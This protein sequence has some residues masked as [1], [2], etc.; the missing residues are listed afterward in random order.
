MIRAWEAVQKVATKKPRTLYKCWDEYLILRGIDITTREGKRG[1][2]R[3]KKFAQPMPDVVLNQDT[4]TALE[5]VLDTFQPA[6][7]KKGTL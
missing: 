6:E 5:L 2:G 7:I 4:P 3:W 1:H